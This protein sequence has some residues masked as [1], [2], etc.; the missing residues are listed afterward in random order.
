VRAFVDFYLDVAGDLVREVG[1]VPLP[2]TAY[3]LVGERWENR[4]TGTVFQGVT[5]GLRIEDV[6]ARER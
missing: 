6:L 4:R 1:Y 3:D 5:P 2:R